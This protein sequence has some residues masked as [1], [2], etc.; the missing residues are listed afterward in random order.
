AAAVIPPEDNT[1]VAQLFKVPLGP[2]AFFKEAHVKLRPVE[3]S[4][5][6]VYLCGTAHAPKHI[7]E[8]ISQANGAAGRALTLLSRDIVTVSGSVCEVDEASCVSC[9]ACIAA[10]TYGAIEFHE[11]P[12][13]KK[14]QVNPVLCKGDGVCNAKCPTGA[15]RLKHFTDEELLSQIDAALPEE[16]A[17]EEILEAA[18]GE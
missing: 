10:C 5:E 4:A 3:F 9:G 13:G 1:K 12:K 15:I 14:A 2:D 17:L 8:T 11:T 18:V 16:A 6:G 7:Q